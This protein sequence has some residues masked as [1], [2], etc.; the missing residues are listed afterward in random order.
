MAIAPD[1]FTR[2]AAI[3]WSGARG[4]SHKGIALAICGIGDAAPV[5]VAPPG[6]A[7]SRTGI[8][9]WLLAQ[10]DTELLVGLDISP[11]FAFRD[12][13]AYFPGWSD[14]P[15]DARALWAMV[16]AL[17]ENDADFAA[18]GVLADPDIRRHFRQQRDCGDLFPGGAGRMRVCEIG[19]RAMG[20]SPTSCFNL[21]GAAQ[22]GKASL[23]GM[24]VLHHL[25]GGVPIWP[26][27]PV[28]ARGAL[29]VEIY[30]TIAARA[31]GIRKGLSKMRDAVALDSALL[32]LGSQPHVPL[33]RYDDHATDAILT[34][35]WLRANAA[36]PDLWA[37]KG[38]TPH[39][40]RT[41]GWTFGVASA[42]KP[43]VPA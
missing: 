21:V 28:P 32:A 3:D 24:R 29:I 23:T 36:R 19:Q 17:A 13:G 11:A 1:R 6:R 9:D 12:E 2:F 5:L 35:A 18:D 27:D 39:V 42:M 26:F 40:A 20:L 8:R 43:G 30:T 25:R 34:A 41:E 7:W 16:D 15:V 10:A 31:A 4:S 14:S 22:V 33:P 38:L 37:P